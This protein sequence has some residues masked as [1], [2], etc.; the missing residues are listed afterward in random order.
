MKVNGINELAQA[1]EYNE[2]IRNH[3][4]KAKKTLISNRIKELLAEG[5]DKEMAKTIANIEYSYN[6]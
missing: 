4:K 2:I 3:E 6:L 5:I 1:I